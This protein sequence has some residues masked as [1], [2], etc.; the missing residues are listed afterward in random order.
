ML[1]LRFLAALAIT[2]VAFFAATSS[3]ADPISGLK[4]QAAGLA[5]EEHAALLALYSLDSRLEGVRSDLAR[6][7]ARVAELHRQQAGA[8]M[9][10]RVARRTLAIAEQRLGRTLIALYE[11]S[12]DD[13]LAVILGATSF[14][15]ALDSLDN[16]TQ[17]AS[18]HGAVAGQARAAR[19]R[20]ASVA[21]SLSIRAQETRRLEAEAIAKQAEL[22]RARGDRSAYLSRVRAESSRL[23]ERIT[24]V[25]AEARAAE[26][27]AQAVTSQSTAAGSATTFTAP[28][29][30][31]PPPAPTPAPKPA[32]PLE[33]APIQAPP[34]GAHTLTVTATAY[35]GGGT[36]A[37]GIP[38]GYGVVAVDPTVIPL[39]TR[40]TI[41]GYGEGVAADTGSAV[42]GA[43]VD[44]W[45]PT[46]AQAE[47]WGTKT[48]TITLH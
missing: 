43:W 10:L 28:P 8:R 12:R 36:T 25:E 20:I 1:G 41:P 34:S 17:I 48:L 42:K 21:R 3:R 47:A 24:V 37:T 5:A 16:L 32:V 11:S 6:I 31:A 44:V 9:E 33:P 29:E 27:R 19:H 13:P 38:V 46:A 4:Q 26:A 45:V 15:D 18:A 39:G 40:M 14:I 35:S 2:F 7:R 22:D 30:P 23:A